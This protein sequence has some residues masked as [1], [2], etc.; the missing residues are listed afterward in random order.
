M[1]FILK[2]LTFLFRSFLGFVALIGSLS[3]GIE[4]LLGVPQFLLNY[5]RKNTQGLSVV[6]IVIWLCG[7]LYK[8][9]YYAGTSS[10]AALVMCAFFQICMDVCILSQF[11][12]YRDRT[13]A[14]RP[15]AKNSSEDQTEE[16][17]AKEVKPRDSI[18][19]VLSTKSGSSSP[20]VERSRDE[21]EI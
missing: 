4:A 11:W 10:P 13:P 15:K 14:E 19:S 1:F 16:S 17:E 7:D 9:S 18:Y 20:Y 6:L 3:S 12:V 2:V 5:Q 21:E 8:F